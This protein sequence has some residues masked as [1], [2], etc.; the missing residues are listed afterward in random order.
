MREEL[1]HL[2]TTVKHGA[3]V[4]MQSPITAW[5]VAFAT[6]LQ[7]EW[8][9]WGSA[10]ADFVTSALGVVLVIVLIRLHLHKTAELIRQSK[11]ADSDSKSD[12]KD[13]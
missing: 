13:K 8:L 2:A 10:L 11:Q 3:E 1:K 5:W 4:A 7:T 9:D 6:Y 12:E